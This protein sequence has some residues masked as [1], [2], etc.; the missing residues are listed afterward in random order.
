MA[1][2]QYNFPT[3]IQYGPGAIRL[4]PDALKEAGKKR[5][6]VVT[7]RGLAPLRPVTETAKLL[8]AAG[9]GTAVFSGM[10]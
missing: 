10:P 8:E 4:L 5:P 1:I 9:L 6:L 3:R 2:H 7:D